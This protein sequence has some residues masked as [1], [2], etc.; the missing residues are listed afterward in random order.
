MNHSNNFVYS[1]EQ[2]LPQN[3]NSYENSN[4]Y[5]DQSTYN[6]FNKNFATLQSTNYIGN[7]NYKTSSQMSN[8]SGYNSHALQPPHLNS[9][10]VPN[11]YASHQPPYFNAN[12][13]NNFS[14]TQ[15][16]PPHN[17]ETSNSNRYATMIPNSYASHQSS[18]FAANLTN[19]FSTTQNLS[20]LSI[21]D[22]V[23]SQN[24]NKENQN[25]TSIV[26][27]KA[28]DDVS[29]GLNKTPKRKTTVG[30]PSSKKKKTNSSSDEENGEEKSAY[31]NDCKSRA[32]CKFGR[33]DTI[34]NKV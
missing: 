26:L 1:N 21:N 5:F 10:I 28:I 8:Y 4:N 11:H 9:T 22:E 33:Q 14:T 13:T 6:S 29:L 16:H 2:Q 17:Y 20:T 7:S 15:T 25:L 31:I 30:T 18:H 23:K 27:S 3:Q 12:F 34:I 24:S 32:K 19:N